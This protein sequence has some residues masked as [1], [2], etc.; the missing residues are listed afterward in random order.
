MRQPLLLAPLA[1]ALAAGTLS[2]QS[3]PPGQAGQPARRA[4]PST[5]ATAE[6][7]LAVPQA[8]GQA[9]GGGA[10]TPAPP[11][12]IRVDYGQPHLRGRRLFTDSLVPYDRPW[13]TGANA[14][15]TLRT[16]VPLT[17]GGAQL[18]AGTYVVLTLPSRTGWKLILQ[19]EGAPAEYSA[20]NDVARVDLRTRTL[21]APIESF[22]IWLIPSTQP[23]AARGE[24]RMA[25]G[26][27]ELSTDWVV[28]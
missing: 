5:R 6:V 9:A 7:S 27:T 21:P 12:V 16:D 4:M 14:A 23:G 2:A 19:R 17:L 1:L 11:A 24:L 10:A 3:T 13:R 8:P 20:A 25:W 18:D 26:T 22:S 15:T 28:R